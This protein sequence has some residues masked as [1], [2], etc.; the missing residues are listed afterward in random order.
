MKA[1]IQQ[2]LKM[3]KEGTLTDEQAAELLAE[4][5]RNGSESEPDAEG[6]GTRDWNR[7]GIVE[8]LLSKVNTTVKYALDAAFGWNSPGA[9][10]YQGEAY[11]GQVSKNAIHMSRFDLP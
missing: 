6:T 2:V 9:Q 3:N 4:L 1:E 10:G 5:A 8:P 7:S 11:G